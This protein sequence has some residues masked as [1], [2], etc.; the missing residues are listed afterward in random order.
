MSARGHCGKTCNSDAECPSN[1][2]CFSVRE[3]LCDCHLENLRNS[4]GNMPEPDVKDPE[5][6]EEA[7]FENTT[8]TSSTPVW[9]QEDPTPT[10][11]PTEPSPSSDP[12]K[13]AKQKIAPF[14]GAVKSVGEGSVEGRDNASFQVN[15]SVAV[16][17]IV[18]LNVLF[19]YFM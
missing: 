15:M 1:E 11:F 4:V 3:N 2:L 19:S 8:T 13:V 7:F 6:V 10:N 18:T 5:D 12:F 16:V 17:A 14:F 9:N